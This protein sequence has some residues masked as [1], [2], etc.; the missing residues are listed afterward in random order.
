LTLI[1][2]IIIS[3]AADTL[4]NC[5]NIIADKFQN[6]HF[7]YEQGYRKYLYHPYLSVMTDT[8]SYFERADVLVRELRED[9]LLLVFYIVSVILMIV[10][11][12]AGLLI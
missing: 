2:V 7:V 6:Q 3:G 12:I 8:G 9:S 10:C 11:D 4:C 1:V 5:Y